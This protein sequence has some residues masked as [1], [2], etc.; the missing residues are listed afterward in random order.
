M[1]MRRMK[2]SQSPELH[3]KG[4]DMETIHAVYEK[5]VFRP[6]EKVLLPE[7]TEVEFEPRPVQRP[8]NPDASLDAIYGILSE[9]FQRG[10]SDVAA[11][12]DEH[13]P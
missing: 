10:E 9:R 8:A 5:G 13:Q 4:E 3:G 11:R 6:I 7:Q 12:H 2:G 1:E